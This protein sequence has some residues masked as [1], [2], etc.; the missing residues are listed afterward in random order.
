VPAL[1]ALAR[2]FPEHRRVLAAPAALKPLVPLID[3]ELELA[4][5][6]ELEP[7]PAALS[8]AELAV[9]LHG[10]GPDSHRILL[11]AGA[12]RARRL[13]FAHG[14]IAES[15]AA[16]RWRADEHERERW[17]RMLAEQG[18]AADPGDLAVAPPAGASPLD[19]AGPPTVI[20]PGAASA[21]RRWPACRYATVA[22]AELDAGRTVAVTGSASEAGLAHEVA[23]A[24]GLPRTAVLAGRTSLDTLARVVG[25]AGRVV[26]G[27]TGMA[28]LAT[29]VGTPSV[30]LFGPTSP[31]H[32]G[33]PRDPRHR[34]LWRGTAAD[35][36]DP[37]ANRPDPR[38]LRIQADEVIE[39]LAGL[40][41][42]VGSQSG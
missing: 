7:L 28:H 1:R 12:G 24:A 18:V 23:A 42:P 20:H 11:R 33:P 19:P 34:V 15:R 31:A 16:P 37:H 38:L 2:A 14:A 3:P 39:A 26:C 27:D 29:A 32:W 25:A 10:R 17:C 40:P 4:P 36:G 35:S 6:G 22:R 30:V 9:N 13:W 21:A 5:V 8:N 41:Q